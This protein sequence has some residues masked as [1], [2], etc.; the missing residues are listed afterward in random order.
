MIQDNDLSDKVF[1]LGVTDGSTDLR[2]Q[3]K[4][5]YLDE[6]DEPSTAEEMTEINSFRKTP[7]ERI[8]K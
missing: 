2:H 7:E 1:V 5:Q 3:Y 6:V 4:N 8:Y